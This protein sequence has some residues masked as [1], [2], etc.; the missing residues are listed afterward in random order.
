MTGLEAANHS[1]GLGDT[2]REKS[3][4]YKAVCWALTISFQALSSIPCNTNTEISRATTKNSSRWDVSHFC[5]ERNSIPSAS[6]LLIFAQTRPLLA[7]QTISHC[8]MVTIFGQEYTTDIQSSL[9]MWRIITKIR[10]S[11]AEHIIASCRMF[12]T[13]STWKSPHFGT[14]ADLA[15][16]RPERYHGCI[17]ACDNNMLDTL[18]TVGVYQDGVLK[19]D[20]NGRETTAHLVR[21]LEPAIIHGF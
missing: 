21:L 3:S 15:E 4:W 5:S 11:S 14:R 13:L 1:G 8:R 20:V 10:F 9:L 19:K 18:A 6:T 2:E 16:N 17:D 7:I 12:A